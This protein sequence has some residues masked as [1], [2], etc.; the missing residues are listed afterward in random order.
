MPSKRR[1]EQWRNALAAARERKKLRMAS[2][3]CPSP[4]TNESAQKDPAGSS[5]SDQADC[6]NYDVTDSERE[7]GIWVWNSSANERESDSDSANEDCVS[8][9]ESG[10]PKDTSVSDQPIITWNKGG[11]KG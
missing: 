6:G 3:C 1:Q 10:S 11:N 2:N 5:S 7:S 9:D 4:S 8:D